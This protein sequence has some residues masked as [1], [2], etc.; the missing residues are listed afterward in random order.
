M[1]CLIP[2]TFIFKL[3]PCILVCVHVAIFVM[4]VVWTMSSFTQHLTGL[5]AQ[6]NRAIRQIKGRTHPFIPRPVCY[7]R[8]Q[9][10]C[11]LCRKEGSA[12]WGVGMRNLM[13]W[14]DKPLFTSVFCVLI[15][16]CC[17]WFTFLANG[18]II[19]RY[20]PNNSF[21]QKR[22]TFRDIIC[23]WYFLLEN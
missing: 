9:I 22:K 1:K 23:P 21:W 14:I 4:R 2:E 15:F 17:C 11:F 20:N 8:R 13:I 19:W 16:C 10:D 3:Q 6:M 7:T 12:C 5:V 18:K